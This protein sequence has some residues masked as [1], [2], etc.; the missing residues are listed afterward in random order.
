MLI[1]S[2]YS[3]QNI[4]NCKFNKNSAQTQSRAFKVC[5]VQ[6]IAPNK[7]EQQ[8]SLINSCLIAVILVIPYLIRN[9]SE[10]ICRHFVGFHPTYNSKINGIEAPKK[11]EV[12]FTNFIR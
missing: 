9:L 10:F 12:V 3:T 11:E 7:I 4:Q 6:F 8:E 1:S 2:N 5:R